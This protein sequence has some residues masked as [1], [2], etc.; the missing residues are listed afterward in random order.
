MESFLTDL[1]SA[2]ILAAHLHPFMLALFPGVGG[3]SSQQNSTRSPVRMTRTRRSVIFFKAMSEF[4]EYNNE[5]L[6]QGLTN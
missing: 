4:I 1:T 6:I 5:L 2:D 3:L